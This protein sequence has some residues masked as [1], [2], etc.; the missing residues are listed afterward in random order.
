MCKKSLLIALLL[1]LFMPWVAQAQ[2]TVTIGDGTSTSRNVP[3]GTYYN[4]SITEQLYTADEIGTAGTISSI[5]FNYAVSIAKD[6]PIAV[7]MMNTDAADLSTGISLADAEL[8]FDGTLSVTGPGWVT[9]TLDTPF[10]YDGT[11]NLLIGINKGYVKYYNDYTWYCT[12]GSNV[13]TRYSQND[14]NAYNAATASFSNSSYD[15]P[16]IQIV[17]TPGA[18]PICEKPETLEYSNVTTNSVD[19]T[20]TGGSGSYEVQYKKTSDQEWTVAYYDTYH[21]TRTINNLEPATAYQAR[22]QSL[23]EGEEIDPETGDHVFVGSGWKTVSFNTECGVLS[24]FPITYGFETSEGF[25]ANASTPTS[26]QF[27]PCW[28]NE[29]TVQTG[30]YSTRVWGTSTSSKHTGSQALILPDKGNSSNPAKTMLVFPEMNFTDANGYVVSFWIYRNGS[31]SS[32]EG[33]KLY[34]SDCDTIGPNAV[35]LGHYSRNYGIAYPVVEPTS[36]WYQYETEPITMTGSVHIIFEG[37]SYYGNATYVDDIEIKVAPSCFKPTGL[38]ASNVT[39]HEATINWTSEATAWQIQLNDEDALDVTEATYTFTGL[40]A[41][42]T[43]SVKVRTNCDGT[44]SEWTNPVNFATTVACPAPAGLAV[45]TYGMSANFTWESDAESFDVAYSQTSIDNPDSVI[46][47][48][49]NT[50]EFELTNYISLGDHYVWVRANCGS[51]G[52]SA[53]AGPTSFHIGYCVPNPSSHDGQGI[54]GVSFGIGDYVVTNGDGSASLPASAPFYGDYSSMIGAVQAGVESTIAITTSTG[55]Y[56]YT[57]VIWVDFDNSMSFEDSEVVYVGKAS[58][59]NGTLEATITIPA[60]QELGDYRMRIYGADSYFNNFYNSGT[61]NWNAAHDPCN[62]GTYRHAH[63]YTLRVL[64]APS[65]LTPTDLTINYT[66]GTEAT[67]SWNSDAEAWNMRV[68]GVDV[69]GVITNPYTLTGLELATTYE[70]EVQANC[71]SDLSEWAGPVSFTTD[72]CMPENQC[73]ITFELTDSYGDGWNGAYIDVVDAITGVSLGH[74]SNN[75]IAKAVETETYTLAVCDG[76]E[77]QFVW[78]TGSYDSE[79]SFVIKDVNEEEIVSG[80]SSDLPFNY[81]VNCTVI[82]CKKPTDLA[83]S[84]IGGRSA[85]LSWTEN[86]EAT[87]W[88]VEITNIDNDSTIVWTAVTNPYTMLYLDPETNYSVRVLPHCEVEKWSDPITFTTTEACPKPANMSVT[89]V[90]RNSATINWTGY[91]ATYDLRYAVA[92]ATRNKWYHYDN[93]EY[94]NNSVG[95]GGNEFWWAIMLPAGSFTETILTKTS[96]YDC[97]AMTGTVTIFNDGDTAPAGDTLA[98][99]DVTLTGANAFV[100][101]EFDEPV[102]IDPSKNLWIVYYNGSGATYPA[103]M[104]TNDDDPNARWVSLDGSTWEDIGDYSIDGSFM[105][106]ACLVY[107]FNPEELVWSDV[108]GINANTYDLTGL[109]SETRYAVQVRSNCGE[110]GESEWATTIFTTDKA[111][112]WNDPE[113]WPE[114]EVPAEY[115]NVTLPAHTT[116][117]IPDS[118]IAFADTITFGEGAS[119][120]I[121]NGGQLYHSNEVP[122]TMHLAY[123]P[124]YTSS[125][126]GEPENG[127][128]RLIA[129]PVNPGVAVSS[130]GLVP[131]I[132]YPY[133]DLYYFDQ[134][135]GELVW[136]NYKNPA[137][138][139]DSLFI[140]KGY[141][142]SNAQ[143]MMGLFAGNTLPTSVDVKEPL[144]Y[145]PDV[146]WAGWNLVGNPF[147]CMAYINLPYYKINGDG[148]AIAQAEGNSLEVFEGV[149][150]LAEQEGDTVTFSTTHGQ[151]IGGGGGFEPD[152]E[153]FKM[154]TLNLNNGR[155]LID[156]A[157]VRFDEGRQL[158]KLQMGSSAKVYIPKDGSDYAIVSSDDMGEMPVSFKAENNGTYTLSFTSEEVSFS[159]LHLIDNMTGIDIDLLQTPSYSFEAKTTDYASRFK[160]VFCTGNTMEDNFA[161]YSN[162]SFVINNEGEATLQ[163]IDV[164]GRIVKSESINGSASINVNAAAG[165]YMLRLINGDNVKVQ[166]IVVR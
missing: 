21:T 49:S 58:S 43:Y 100:E 119:I 125:K 80:S 156:R 118:Y 163:V 27:G 37:H 104:S 129:A 67:I 91:G 134:N 24:N 160:L 57:F 154:L 30:S 89:N 143:N 111:Y 8:V 7:Y 123:N 50:T 70:V 93:G 99:A 116:V 29:A 144:E 16:N 161:F 133:V 114:D 137:N 148:D 75:N 31:S 86:G 121:E 12:G 109:D 141:L 124:N 98:Q 113:T 11:S 142:Y 15:R 1:A 162:G 94:N 132:N 72:L 23:C 19:L 74:M 42:T 46:I 120:L 65:C 33:F 149:F 38:A 84:E 56:P 54:T 22:V 36:G 26:N 71:G 103:A 139:F 128:Y 122:V 166:K 2:E 150:V 126:D 117:I 44:Y 164:T 17:I 59:G 108:T 147:T 62:S 76:R 151:S 146:L 52:Y 45:T 5:S 136:I 155:N 9:I 112:Y 48:Q 47:G 157:I 13:M 81:T 78:H 165:V 69:N 3:I 87:E 153:E 39:A 40:D 63:D 32:P 64:E 51:E 18:G 83:V 96:V 20:W 60:T 4:Y 131:D 145:N 101:T 152:P 14:S 107:D 135:A 35:E 53:W 105:I 158:L 159:Y 10:A 77:I 41:E 138:N 140:K 95:T 68:N 25:P 6:F 79:C 85:V 97:M 88:E 55:S 82:P 66:G 106:R 110:D 28:R 130:T 73:E 92:P 127:E 34:V 102:A 115:T 90:T 61:T